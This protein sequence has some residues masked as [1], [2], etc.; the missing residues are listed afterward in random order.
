MAT[1]EQRLQAL[2]N[3]STLYEIIIER[4]QERYLVQYASKS[5]NAILRGLRKHGEAIAARFGGTVTFAKCARDG[6]YVGDWH[7]RDS[8]RTE[9]E[10]I[11]AGE[12]PTAW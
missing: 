1:I 12:Y 11:I 10:A 3:R 8:G 6:A 5:R 4:D 2:S 9:R 7:V